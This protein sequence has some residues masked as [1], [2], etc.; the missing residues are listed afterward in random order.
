MTDL[1]IIISQV[2]A[3]G[4]QEAMELLNLPVSCFTMLAFGFPLPFRDS[5]HDL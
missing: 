3:T 4:L 2:S 5:C 1:V